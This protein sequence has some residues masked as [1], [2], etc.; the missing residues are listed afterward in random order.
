MNK[1]I[2]TY[3]QLYITSTYT[4]ATCMYVHIK[5]YTHAYGYILINYIYKGR[6]GELG[7]IWK[8][9]PSPVKKSRS[10]LGRGARHPPLSHPPTSLPPQETELLQK[11]SRGGSQ[12][13]TKHPDS[14]W[15]APPPGPPTETGVVC[16]FVVFLF[17]AGPSDPASVCD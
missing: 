8:T 9:E 15:R 16:P 14:L 5:N 11:A 6:S 13:P 12:E 7:P 1:Y 10:L 3:I 17:A 4:Q 2:Q